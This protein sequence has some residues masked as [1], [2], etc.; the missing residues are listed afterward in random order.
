MSEHATCIVFRPEGHAPLELQAV[1][2]ALK[3]PASFV[4]LDVANPERHMLDQLA[5]VLAL[6]ELV[7]ED[8]HAAHQRPKLESYPDSLFLALNAAQRWQGRVHF[9]EIHIFCGR[10]YLAVIRHGS[11]FTGNKAV[12]KLK[13]RQKE[14]DAGTALHALLDLIVDEYKPV[15]EALEEDHSALEEE[16]L[17]EEF[18]GNRL[19]RLYA[20]RRELLGL[21]VAI[22]PLDEI[23]RSLIREHPEIVSKG[24]KAYYRDIHDHVVRLNRN[25]ERLR[26]MLDDAMHL[27]A[28]AMT[29][30]Q[31]E[32]VQKLAGWGA[33][34]AIPTLVFSLYGMNFVGMPEL[35]WALGYPLTLLGTSA[36]CLVLYKHLKRRGWI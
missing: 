32:S 34:L 12:E 29:L 10:N 19:S 4:W 11:Y 5:E 8:A 9:G 30:E 22:N 14:P 31:N 1:S 7:V 23:C 27:T 26:Q 36:A 13:L 3:E 6:H 21:Q 2:D 17:A 28:A 16:M 24:L 25:L 15:V 18:R 35:H 33:I 20:L